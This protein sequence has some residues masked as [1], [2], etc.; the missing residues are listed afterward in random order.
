MRNSRPSDHP[1]PRALRYL[2]VGTLALGACVALGALIAITG[3]GP[4]GPDAA[5]LDYWHAHRTAALTAVSLW[6]NTAGSRLYLG[7]ILPGIAAILLLIFRR[8]LAAIA[9]VAAG[10]IDYPAVNALKSVLLRPRPPHP[11]ISV[12][13]TAYPSGHVANLVVLLALTGFALTPRNR[14]W[15]WPAAAI[16]SFAM[17]FSRTYLDAHWLTDTVGAILLGLGVGAIL[18]A[19]VLRGEQLIRNRS[20]RTATKTR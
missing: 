19:A 9:F 14:R 7:Y 8:P 4:F 10:L 12:T 6:F 15:W 18:W 3:N 5:F 2:G 20:S 1:A 17:S 11:D 16:A 13:L